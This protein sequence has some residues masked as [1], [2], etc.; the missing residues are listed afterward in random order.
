[1]RNR[2]A[3]LVLLAA[4]AGA[5]PAEAQGVR[6]GVGIV[7]VISLEDE[8]GSDF[9]I[10][11]QVDFLP[12]G[13]PDGHWG[14]RVDGAY[15]FNEFSNYL[16]WNGDVAYHFTTASP[17]IHPFLLGGAAL[18]HG[19]DIDAQFGIGAG[20]GT[21]IHL[22][23]SPVGLYVDARFQRFFDPGFSQ[24]QLGGGVRFGQGE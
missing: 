16:L 2:L 21:N 18:R 24:L 20:A 7:P 12:T 17:S 10:G 11:G 5:V 6:F 8:G 4:M 9:G 1:M 19:G 13:N 23:G 22:S 3:G 14:A 15:I